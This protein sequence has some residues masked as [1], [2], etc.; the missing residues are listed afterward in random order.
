[1]ENFAGKQVLVRTER[2]GVHFGTLVEKDGNEL[3]LKKA[4]RLWQ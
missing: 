4:K 3:I 1:M 2:A